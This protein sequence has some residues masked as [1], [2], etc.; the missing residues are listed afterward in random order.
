MD[1][2]LESRWA[3]WALLVTAA[4]LAGLIAWL[5]LAIRR[6]WKAW[7][8]GR[9]MS[10]AASGETL[11]ESWLVARGFQILERQATQRGT[12]LVDGEPVAFDVRAD[13]IVAR[14]GHRLLVEVKTGDAADPRSALTRRQLREYR[15][16]FDVD[17]LLL[18]DASQQRLRVIEFPEAPV[19]RRGV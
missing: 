15:D 12:I 3:F 10:A 16:L 14:G 17:G 6:A 19:E 1:T 13:L 5:A 18:F 7:R 11:A 2:M 4:L 8:L 9:R